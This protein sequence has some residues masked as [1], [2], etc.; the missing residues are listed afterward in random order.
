M[1]RQD[2][3][4]KCSAWK[5][6]LKKYSWY[7]QMSP[8]KMLPGKMSQWQL[9]SVLDHP[10]TLCLKSERLCMAIYDHVWLC[11][12]MHDYVLLCMTMCDYVWLYVTMYD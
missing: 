12:T 8:E 1:K 6:F 2:L 5:D 10:R 9:E 3:Y 4:R 7:G 11:L